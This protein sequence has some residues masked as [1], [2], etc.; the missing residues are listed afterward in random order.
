MNR[1]P[2]EPQC[3]TWLRY[4]PKPLLFYHTTPGLANYR[5]G[6]AA[7]RSKPGEASLNPGVEALAGEIARFRLKPPLQNISPTSC[8]T[9]S[10]SFALAAHLSRSPEYTP[11]SIRSQ[12]GLSRPLRRLE[13]GLLWRFCAGRRLHAART[14]PGARPRRGTWVGLLTRPL[15][16][17]GVALQSAQNPERI[18]GRLY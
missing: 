5:V 7:C 9:L 15:R 6:Q 8:K 4:A 10:L 11:A 2:L 16:P 18:N 12:F 14:T 13:I 1:G 17:F 3:A